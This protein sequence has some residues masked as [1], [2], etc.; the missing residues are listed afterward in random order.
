M[1]PAITSEM[2]RGCLILPRGKARIW[3][4][5][6]I[7]TGSKDNGEPTG[8]ARRDKRGV[9]SWIIHSRMGFVG[10]YFEGLSPDSTPP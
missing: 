1:I 5:L 4:I 6:M 7:I 8:M 10:K 2:T 3:I 9:H